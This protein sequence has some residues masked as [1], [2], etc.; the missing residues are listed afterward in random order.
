MRGVVAAGSVATARAAA[1]VLRDGGN[2]VDAAVAGA[3]ACCVA[4]PLLTSVGGAGIMIVRPAGGEPIAIDFFSRFPGADG[5]PAQLDFH[6]IEVDFGAATQSFHVGRGAAAVPLALDGLA[7]ASREFGS[8]P[9]ARV[10]EPSM[11][12][13]REGIVADRLTALTFQ[14]L[15]P[16]L[17]RD[18]LCLA[19]IA[20]G[21]PRDRAPTPGAIIRNPTLARTLAE[22][23]ACGRT[24]ARLHDG[25]LAEFGPARG[26]LIGASDVDTAEIA[27]TQPHRF[28]IGEWTIW[29]SPRLGG[30]LVGMIAEQLA[31]DPI[32]E[33]EPDEVLRQ[34]Q[35][36]LAGHR[37]RLAAGS[38][39]SR[40]STTHVSV[41]DEAGG[42][43]SVTLTC[44]EGC[45]HVVSG[46]GVH[47][48]NFLG[49]ED[50]NPA[51]W[52][53][54]APRTPLPTMIAPTIAVHEDGRVV[55]LGS[56]GANRI[57]SAVAQV[58]HGFARR[59]LSIHEAVA[60]PRVHAEDGASWVELDARSDAA[61]VQARL[62]QA[63]ARVLP[64]GRRDFF[65][66]G[67][68]AAALARD[69][70]LDG[71]GDSRRDGAVERSS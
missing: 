6:A 55:A 13:A 18:P 9:L 19:E 65:F 16:I 59:G 12:M 11:V 15:W 58:L 3:L 8:L 41:V 47:L 31:R 29:T 56:G 50:L 1:G 68:H 30:R 34:A 17:R 21:L 54:H 10:V 69:G 26:G 35:A 7:F 64:F 43:A 40:G 2:A 51:G 14:L 23:A 42:A 71:V 37:A 5:R 48:N 4:E 24:P 57:R 20:D 33:A 52:H 27:V 62:G 25:M 44:G 66:G 28:V 45:G 46:T 38:P 63:F 67:V 60:A 53:L 49:E 39:E 70:T 61:G 36:S 32:A 22:Y